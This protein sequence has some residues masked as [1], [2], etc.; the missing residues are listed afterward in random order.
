MTDHR[1]RTVEHLRR[2]ADFRR[3]Y[4][5]K[6]SASNAWLVVYAHPNELPHNRLGL[7]VGK[8]HG[9]AVVRNR[10][11]RQLRET[12][13]LTKTGLPVGFDVILIP[14]LVELPRAAALQSEMPTVVRRAMKR[15]DSGNG[16]SA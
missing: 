15:W 16:G 14:R 7:A 10:L 4:E 9:N 5:A 13:R 1:F 2:P 3:A 8:K 6:R 12:Y 11:R